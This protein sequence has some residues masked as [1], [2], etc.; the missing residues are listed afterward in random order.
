MR[1][2]NNLLDAGMKGDVSVILTPSFCP[3]IL[4]P[5]FSHIVMRTHSHLVDFECSRS[6]VSISADFF[7]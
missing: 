6:S 5:M 7:E 4:F 3:K 2:I 1:T